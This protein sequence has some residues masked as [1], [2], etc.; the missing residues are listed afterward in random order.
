MAV[1]FLTLGAVVFAASLVSFLFG[2]VYGILSPGMLLFW[3]PGDAWIAAAL[4]YLL[5]FC[6]LAVV[7]STVAGIGALGLYNQG[8]AGTE[9][10]P[11]GRRHEG[12]GSVS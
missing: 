3:Y 6:A 9:L 4:L 10:G 11:K 7:C 8:R 12:N 5:A 1:L 2:A